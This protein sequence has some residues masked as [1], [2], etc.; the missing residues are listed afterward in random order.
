VDPKFDEDTAKKGT[1]LEGTTFIQSFGSPKQSFVDEKRD[2]RC[3]K[4]IFSH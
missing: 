1:E 3:F 2:A 4:M